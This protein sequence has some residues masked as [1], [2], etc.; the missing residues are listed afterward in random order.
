MKKEKSGFEKTKNCEIESSAL[1]KNNDFSLTQ[2]KLIIA[3][4]GKKGSL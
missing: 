4:H 2:A 1:R 3:I